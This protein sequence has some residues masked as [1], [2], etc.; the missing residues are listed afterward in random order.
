M[1][2]RK[3][4]LLPF[5]NGKLIKD[6]IERAIFSIENGQKNNCFFKF[7]IYENISNNPT[8]PAF[9]YIVAYLIPNVADQLRKKGY[10]INDEAL[11]RFFEKEFTEPIKESIIDEEIEYYNMKGLKTKELSE[12]A[13]KIKKWAEK[14]GLSLEVSE[15]KDTK[16]P[17]FTDSYA[18]ALEQ[19]W[20][21][22]KI[23]YKI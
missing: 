8:I 17:E 11:Y 16:M 20:L 2:I 6:D 15:R 14:L 7:I 22:L 13:E 10:N 18:K 4:G 3:V 5:Q 1:G 9:K 12:V 19:Q 21:D 23:K